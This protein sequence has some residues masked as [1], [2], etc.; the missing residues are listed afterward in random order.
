MI[1]NYGLGREIVRHLQNDEIPANRIGN[2]IFDVMQIF[3]KFDE[4]TKFRNIQ[5]HHSSFA[6]EK[7]VPKIDFIYFF[8]ESIMIFNLLPLIRLVLHAAYMYIH[9]YSDSN[10][11]RV[12]GFRLR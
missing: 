4:R 6:E 12:G 3:L 1:A 10:S 11:E 7:N 5:F 8:A 2:R 9:T